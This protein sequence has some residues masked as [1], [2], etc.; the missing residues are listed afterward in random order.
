MKKVLLIVGTRPEAI[1]VAP[2][3]LAMREEGS[4][5]SPEVCLTG[6]HPRIAD[7]AFDVFG[8][9]ADSCLACVPSGGD[10]CVS[11]GSV[12]AA[13][14]MLIDERKPDMV[15]VQGDT[16]S[17]MAGGLAACLRRV[18]LAHVEAGLR[19]GQLDD[20]FPEEIARTQLSHLA[21]W[22][23]APTDAAMD[24]LYAEGISPERIYRVGNTVVDAMRLIRERLPAASDSPQKM[25]LVTAHRRENWGEPLERICDAVHRLAVEHDDWRFVFSVHPNPDIQ[26]IV[27]RAFHDCPWLTLLA[28][29]AYDAWVRQLVDCDLILTDSGG[30]QEEGC[31]LGRPV[32]VLRK[33]TE[34]PEAVEAGAAMVI[35]T[36]VDDIVYHTQRVMSDADVYAR[37][38]QPRSTYGD[39]F[40][41]QRI[42][43]ALRMELNCT[44]QLASVIAS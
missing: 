30:M 21:T 6:Q 41:A 44:P 4:G 33:T 9:K 39:G 34:R 7:E 25:I 15:M 42:V 14:G 23:F 27:R 18:P 17:A 22:N 12:I 37:M 24:N 5:L 32:L 36:Q 1:K 11:A 20:P 13:V 38:A 26:R 8:I 2:L 28:S 35:G 31:A 19:S 43:A 40:A 29:P 10:L 16:L 3:V